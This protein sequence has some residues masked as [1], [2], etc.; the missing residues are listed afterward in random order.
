MTSCW[1]IWERRDKA[2]FEDGERRADLVVRRVRDLVNEMEGRGS[3]EEVV[4]VRGVAEDG[5]G[6]R[7]PGD[8]VVKVNVDA[9]IME[10]VGVGLGAVCRND[11]GEVEWC[12]VEQGSVAMVPEEAEAAA[13][14][15]GLKEARRINN[16]KV[17]LE[18]DCSNVIH[19]LQLKRKGRSSIF[20]IYTDIYA[21]CNSFDFASFNWSRRSSNKVAHE[22]PHLRP[23]TI[24]S[25]RWLASIPLDISDV[26]R[27]DFDN[28]SI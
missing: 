15:H 1:A 10:G 22:L 16:R 18:G 7:R 2:I 3:L 21:L 4:G 5:G 23:W 20:L 13:I 24:G 14:L 27:A 26:V 11:R 12:G 6:W 8:G 17:I 9:A 28:I 25:R 19:D